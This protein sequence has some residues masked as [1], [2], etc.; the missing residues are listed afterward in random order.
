MQSPIIPGFGFARMPEICFGAGA[1]RQLPQR[2]A[3]TG[4]RVL[5]VTGSASFLATEAYAGLIEALTQAEV[6]QFQVAVSGEPSP[7]FVD[8]TVERYR[9]EKLDWVVGIG[10]GS[11]MDAGKAISAMLLQEGSV[12]DYLEGRETR[13][14][15]GRKIPYVAVP[16]SS[17]TGSEATKNAVLSEIGTQGYKNSLRH[18]NLVPDLALIDPELMRSCPPALTAACGLDALTQLLEAYVSTKASPISD[19]LALSGLEHFAAGFLPAYEQGER[20]IVARSHMAYAAFLS[21]VTLANAGLGVVHG[22]AS[23]IGGYFDV[24]HGVVCGTLIGEATRINLEVLFEDEEKNRITLEKFARVG[25]LLAGQSSGSTRLDCAQ[26][27]RILQQWIERTNIQKL[28]HYGISPGDF[29]KILDKTN[30]KNSP[31]TLDRKQ[32]QSILEAR[33]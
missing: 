1:L 25:A 11:V 27:L 9:D 19:A 16:T 30:N 17:G 13:K 3:R 5:L 23:P 15:D 28:G 2:I 7:S 20:D 18:D 26:L 31:V 10:G 14:H 8:R 32:M 4:S 29:T 6:W 22:F 21:G 33:L 24:P 12:A